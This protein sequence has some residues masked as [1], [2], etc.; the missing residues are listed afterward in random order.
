MLDL[1]VGLSSASD[2]A[3]HSPGKVAL[4]TKADGVMRIDQVDVRPLH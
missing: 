3:L 4:W 2:H 1:G